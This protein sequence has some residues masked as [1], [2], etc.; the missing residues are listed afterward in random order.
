V[1]TDYPFIRSWNVAQGD[2][3]TDADVKSSAKVCVVGTTVV[4]NLFPNGDAVGQ[5][6]RIKNVPFRVVGVLEKKGGNMM[7][8]DQDDTIIAPY[9]TVMKR[10]S[11]KTK[12]D[13]IQVSA[14]SADQVQEAQNQVD[15]YLRQRHRIPPGG[16]ADFQMRS[17]E[18]IAQTQAASMGILRNLLLAIAAVSLFVGGIGIMNI[19]LVSVTERTRE[20]GIRMAIGARGSDVLTQFLVESIVM[21]VLGGAVGLVVGIGGASL[22]LLLRSPTFL[23]LPRTDLGDPLRDG[24]LEPLRRF[25]RVVEPGHDHPGQPLPDRSLDR[26][27]VL[28]L[29][30]RHERERVTGRLG[31][32]RPPD[33][34][35]VV[36]GQVRDV[37]VHH[38]LELLHVDPAGHDVRRHQAAIAPRLEPFQRIG[39]LR[40]RS[41]AVDP[42]VGH[43]VA[44]EIIRQP[45]GPVLRSREDDHVPDVPAP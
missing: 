34:M 12:L 15:A 4:D 31:P 26:R 14:A 5:I 36:L 44:G 7:G 16:D 40:L 1:S 22:G 24:D 3:F 38:V 37:E 18:E 39:A 2:F 19:M 27:E 23:R 41:V 25:A 42:R 45:V 17:Q 6:V 21:S 28:L 8:Q 13:M 30:G 11:G 29:F 33:P 10:L 32:R 20:I 35:D 43:P 9:T